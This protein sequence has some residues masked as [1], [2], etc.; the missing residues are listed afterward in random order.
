MSE[1][2]LLQRLMS[3]AHLG[4]EETSAMIGRIVDGEVSSPE[5]AALL[6]ALAV[7]GETVDELTGAAEAL[8]ARV[9]RVPH[10]RPDCF[11]TC[12]TGGDGRGSFNVSTAAAFVVAAAGVP[13]AKHGNRAI[14]SKSGS[15]DLLAALGIEIEE[16]PERS[17]EQLDRIGIA[18]LFA[19]LHHPAMKAVAPVR[20][21]LGVRTLFNLIGPLTNPA[22]AKRQL[23]GVYARDKVEPVARVLAALGS[24]RALVVHGADG[25]DEITTTTTTFVCEVR[26]GEVVP[27]ELQPGD[28]GLPIAAPGEFLG[29]EPNENADRLE[30]LFAGER[31]PLADLVAANA[32]AAL[33]IAGRAKTLRAGVELAQKILAGGGARA[34]L[35]ELRAFR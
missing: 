23:L 13:V 7:K 3:G 2:L 24:E 16:P 34:K 12:G 25:L 8:R 11:D 33:W 14:S 20:K 35:G 21:A 31:G 22:G 18:F 9:R 4:R 30:A 26:K 29:G 27:G 17:A 32:G 1:R 10:R 15:A 6:V 5:I 19:P 28:L